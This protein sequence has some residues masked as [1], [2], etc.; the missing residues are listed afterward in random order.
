M[1]NFLSFI[2]DI[3]PQI[4]TGIIAVV[5]T[6]IAQRFRRGVTK[7]EEYRNTSQSLLAQGEYATILLQPMAETIEKM[8]KRIDKLETENEQL[9]LRIETLEIENAELR[10]INASL[11]ARIRFLEGVQEKALHGG[12]GD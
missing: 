8:E 4:I 6:L 11:R 2:S 9:E 1:E 12:Q 10:S 5:T 3:I 7:S